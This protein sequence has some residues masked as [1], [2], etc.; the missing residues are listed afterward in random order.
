MPSRKLPLS[1]G[2]S[3]SIS[4]DAGS[5]P[6]AISVSAPDSATV[7]PAS[8]AVSERTLTDSALEVPASTNPGFA[9]TAISRVS[10]GS[11]DSSCISSAT[12]SPLRFNSSK[13]RPLPA[14]VILNFTAVETLPSSAKRSGSASSRPNCWLTVRLASKRACS[15]PLLAVICSQVVCAAG[16]SC[17]GVTVTFSDDDAPAGTFLLQSGSPS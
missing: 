13:S 4:A 3:S 17:G 11:S 15:V 5:N 14:L 12:Q 9:N 7:C 6:L 1:P 2:A 10:S 16:A 8:A